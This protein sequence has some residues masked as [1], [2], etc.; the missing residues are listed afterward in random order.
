MEHV[1]A[2]LV[3][4]RLEHPLFIEA[5]VH[6]LQHL[7]LFFDLGTHVAATSTISGHALVFDWAAGSGTRYMRCRH[8][9]SE[10]IFDLC[11]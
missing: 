3:L 7:F 5:S 8:Q 6:H 9:L 2:E 11:T 10:I 4:A 1:H